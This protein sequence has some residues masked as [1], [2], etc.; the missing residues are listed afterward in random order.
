MSIVICYPPRLYGTL[1]AFITFVAFGIG[2]L[3]YGINIFAQRHC[4]GSYTYIFIFLLLPTIGLYGCQRYIR[5]ACEADDDEE[6][7][8][9]NDDGIVIDT[10]L[11]VSPMARRHL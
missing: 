10:A 4:D 5:E 3:N 2:L 7:E 9:S 11:S 8:V 1:Q 6:G